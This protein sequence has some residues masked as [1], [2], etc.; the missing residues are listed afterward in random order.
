[1]TV[2]NKKRLIIDMVAIKKGH[3]NI[4]WNNMT[5]IRDPDG[6]EVWMYEGK[7]FIKFMPPLHEIKSGDGQFTVETVIEYKEID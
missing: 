3:T 1:M 7:K 6:G 5:T 2:L 4:E